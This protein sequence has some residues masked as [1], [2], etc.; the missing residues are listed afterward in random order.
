MAGPKESEIVFQ[1]PPRKLV[2]WVFSKSEKQNVDISKLIQ[3]AKN[4][5]R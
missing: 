2:N 4:I 1:L 5:D 3:Q